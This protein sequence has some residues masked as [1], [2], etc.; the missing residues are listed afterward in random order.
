MSRKM[1]KLWAALAEMKGLSSKP[2]REALAVKHWPE[3]LIL[4]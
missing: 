3:R 2:F 1:L 4:S